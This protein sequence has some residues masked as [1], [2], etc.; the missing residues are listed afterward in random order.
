M[1]GE[2]ARSNSAADIEPGRA[3]A[4]WRGRDGRDHT[5][6]GEPGAPYAELEAWILATF[7]TEV[8]DIQRRGDPAPP[9]AASDAGNTACSIADV[10]GADVG[11]AE[12]PGQRRQLAAP[13]RQASHA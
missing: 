12:D 9:A 8:I 7:A 2:R 6:L 4:V 1:S 5:V 11:N 10:D 3:I 13:A